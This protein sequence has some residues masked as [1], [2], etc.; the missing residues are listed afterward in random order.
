MIGVEVLH[1]LCYKCSI[2]YCTCQLSYSMVD[3]G[4]VY[5]LV[6]H[7]VA[8]ILVQCMRILCGQLTFPTHFLNNFFSSSSQSSR[9]ALP[10]LVS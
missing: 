1:S 4:A 6:Y 10:V 5:V 8:A 9:V 7:T 3:T 2:L